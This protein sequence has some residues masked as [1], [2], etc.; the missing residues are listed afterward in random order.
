MEAVR[1]LYEAIQ[2]RVNS[3]RSDRY[4]CAEFPPIG[5]LLEYA[6]LPESD[7]LRFLRRPQLRALETYWYLR[8][9]E[10]TAKIPDL[11]QNYFILT[12]A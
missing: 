11:Y 4:P 10:R 8:L 7:S 9:I 5:K 12:D 3:W 2:E 1:H 6:H